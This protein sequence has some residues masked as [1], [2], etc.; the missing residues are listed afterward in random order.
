MKPTTE[1]RIDERGD[2]THESWVM[3]GAHHYSG[4][5]VH[6][7]DSEIAH[8]HFIGVTVKRCK[9][10]RDLNRDWLHSSETLLEVHMSQAQWG[11]FVSSFGQGN[12][13]PATL[14]YLTGVGHVSSAPVESRFDESHAEVLNAGEEA[15]QSVQ[16]GYERVMEAFEVGGKKAMRE[17]LRGLAIRLQNA[18]KHMEFAAESLTEHV[19]N[20]IT[21]ARADIEGMVLNAQQQGQLDH[22]IDLQLGQGDVVSSEDA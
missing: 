11:A 5:N 22:P 10:R 15:L 7:F 4:G 2:E 17:A 21:K 9:R 6:L 12:G 13:V 19:E 14:D 1:I 20:V 18:P 3:I 8:Q 16:E